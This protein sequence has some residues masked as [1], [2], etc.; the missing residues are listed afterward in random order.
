MDIRN[1]ITTVHSPRKNLPCPD[2]SS[3]I[4]ITTDTFS[5][6]FPNVLPF[7]SILIS[8]LPHSGLHGSSRY[9]AFFAALVL[10]FI[11]RY[12]SA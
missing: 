3:P 12:T 9:S 8:N 2:V 4:D 6:L 10:N 7:C 5:Y 11:I 1:L